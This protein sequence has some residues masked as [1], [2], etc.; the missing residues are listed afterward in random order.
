MDPKKP[1]TWRIMITVII[2]LGWLIFLSI[3]L[4]FYVSAF[5]IFQNVAIFILSLAIVGGI[6]SF[7]WIPWGMK[8]GG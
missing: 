1:E 2:G 3:W 7:L 8:H 4:F 5:S 6:I